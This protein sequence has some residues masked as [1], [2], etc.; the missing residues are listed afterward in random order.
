MVTPIN[1]SNKY[2]KCITFRGKTNTIVIFSAFAVKY[3]PTMII[4]QHIISI[5]NRVFKVNYIC[6]NIV[7]PK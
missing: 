6:I 3:F 4:F 7:F 1:F 5:C 2:S